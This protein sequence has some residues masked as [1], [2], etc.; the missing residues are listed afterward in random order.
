MDQGHHGP[1]GKLELKA[2]GDVEHD[3]TQRQQH[4]QPA[5]LAQFVADLR[6][7]KFDTAQF[8]AA[9]VGLAQGVEHRRAL[10]V[11]IALGQAHQHILIGAEADHDGALVAGAGQRVADGAEIGAVRVVQLDQGAA[12]KVQAPVELA[13]GQRRDRG[14]DQ[15]RGKRRRA[16]ALAHKIDGLHAAP[17]S[18]TSRPMAR[19]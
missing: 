19:A 1:R 6:P 3:Q 13:Q 5:L 14:Q 8:H 4:R 17:P 11:G 18:V 16:A 12:G 15:Q 9:A 7:H 2:K 10:R